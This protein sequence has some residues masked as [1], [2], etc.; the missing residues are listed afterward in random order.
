MTGVDNGSTQDV[1][2]A[3]VPEDVDRHALW[4]TVDDALAV[5]TPR[6]R[7]VLDPSGSNVLPGTA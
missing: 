2:R 5:M 3:A 6:Y 7:D 4:R 1:A